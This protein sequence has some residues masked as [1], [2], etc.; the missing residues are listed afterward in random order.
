MSTKSF[1]SSSVLYTT[2]AIASLGSPVLAQNI[3]PSAETN[4]LV[5]QNN[6]LYTITGGVV[7]P[8][9]F[10]GFHKFDIFNLDSG[11]IANFLTQ[12][13]LRNLFIG[14]NGGDPSI[15]NGL[16]ELTGSNANFIFANPAGIVFGQGASFNL[17]ADLTV[18]TANRIGFGEDNW[19]DVLG[20][21]DYSALLGDPT[22][23]AFDALEP[24][25]ILNEGDI[26]LEN[27]NLSFY[28]GG[29]AHTGSIKAGKVTI[30]SVDGQTTARFLP[31]GSLI[32]IEV[33]ITPE[34]PAALSTSNLPELEQNKSTNQAA[35]PQINSGD[36]DF[37]TIIS[38]DLDT[39]SSTEIGGDIKVLGK[40]VLLSE[41]AS[42]DASG[43]LGGGDINIGGS[44][45]GKGN[46]ENSQFTLVEKNVAINADAL[47]SGDGGDIIIWAD[48]K[49]DF[50]GT[51]SS[52]GGEVSGD[53]GFA[54]ISGKNSLVYRGDVDLSANN[55]EFGTLLFDPVNITIENGSGTNTDSTFFEENLEALDGN[56]DVVLTATNNI[57]LQDL[58]DNVLD[59]ATGSGTITITADADEDGTGSFIFESSVLFENGLLDDEFQDKI[60]APERNVIINAADTNIGQID[61]SGQ[62]FAGDVSITTSGDLTLSRNIAAF[63]ETDESNMNRQAGGTVTLI[64][65]GDIEFTGCGTSSNAEGAT[66]GVCI[67]T[68]GGDINL[69]SGRDISVTKGFLNAGIRQ[70]GIAPGNISVIATRNIVLSDVTSGIEY[71]D[72]FVGTQSTENAGNILIR[73]VEG[74]VSLDA[75]SDTNST[76][77]IFVSS[78]N[79]SGGQITVEAAEGISI[80]AH[81]RTEAGQNNGISGGSVMLTTTNGNLSI[82]NIS[83]IGFNAGNITLDAGGNIS[84]GTLAAEPTEGNAGQISVDAGGTLTISTDA[85]D[86]TGLT[87]PPFSGAVAAFSANTPG[88]IS[89]TSGGDMTIE[90]PFYCLRVDSEVEA[91]GTLGDIEIGSIVLDSG[92]TIDLINTYSGEI[93]DNTEELVLFVDASNERGNGGTI[94]ITSRGNIKAG[95]MSVSGSGAG[96]SAGNISLTSE[97]GFVDLRETVTLDNG[98]IR[99]SVVAGRVLGDQT[100]SVNGGTFNVTA[101]DKIFTSNLRFWSSGNGGNIILTS[102][103]GG[104]VDIT[105]GNLELFTAG[106][107]D[108]GTALIST[109]GAI[110]LGAI[111]ATSVSGNGGNLTFNSNDVNFLGNVRTAGVLQIE[112]EGDTVLSSDS[113]VEFEL[114]TLRLSSNSGNARLD[115]NLV[116]NN[117]NVDISAE[118]D[119]DLAGNIT[120]NGGNINLQSNN[121]N[122]TT[123]NL[124]AS[125]AGGVGGDVSLNALG[126]PETVIETG[127]IN[128]SGDTGGNIEIF[129]VERISAGQII[130]RGIIG[131]GGNVTIDPNSV[132]IVFIDAQG[133]GIGS[134]GTVDITVTGLFQATGAFVD[135]TGLLSSI[136]TFGG[137]GSGPITIRHDGGDLFIPFI[138]GDPSINGTLGALNSGDFTIDTFRVF[139]GSFFLGN[140]SIITSDRFPDALD[141]AI[142]DTLPK[143][144]EE[145]EAKDKGFFIDEFFTRQFES[146]F[147]G[148]PLAD[149]I[150]I[151]SI[152][153]IQDTLGYIESTTGVKPILVYGLFQPRSVTRSCVDSQEINLENE[154]NFV[155]SD[156]NLYGQL[157]ND[158]GESCFVNPRKFP[159]KD[160]DILTLVTVTDNKEI[161]F[162]IVPNATR[163]SVWEE[164]KKFRRSVTQDPLDRFDRNKFQEYSS[165]FYKWL[166]DSLPLE[167]IEKASDDE[168]LRNLTF[169]LDDVLR[170]IPLAALGSTKNCNLDNPNS[171]E[172]PFEYI[173]NDY[174]VGLMPS[175]SLTE[176]DYQPLVD[177][178]MRLAGASQFKDEKNL[179]FVT[180]DIKEIANIWSEVSEDTQLDFRGLQEHNFN[181]ENV[182]KRQLDNPY[183]IVHLATHGK[184]DSKDNTYILFKQMVDNPDDFRNLEEIPDDYLRLL[185]DT[186][187]EWEVRDMGWGNVNL[188]V[189]SACETAIDFSQENGNLVANRETE[190]G[191]AGFA[192]R[193]ET[194]SVLGSLWKIED[195]TTGAVMARFYSEFIEAKAAEETIIKAEALRRAQLSMLNKKVYMEQGHI[196]WEK[197]GQNTTLL[198]HPSDDNADIDTLN[199]TVYDLTDPHYWSPYTMVGSPW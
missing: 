91:L 30:Q 196:I 44:Y 107:N 77:Q 191:F 186:N 174:S 2:V 105:E 63:A 109:D 23:F 159:P 139:P 172:C 37:N 65:A 24:S 48:N 163:R 112:S 111:D 87:N 31:E 33:D 66:T 1:I 114:D 117:G 10:N 75:N 99:K 3:I 148:D 4:T 39:S 68:F 145:V 124:D 27:G 171:I 128:T 67:E 16:I 143:I 106:N 98:E 104:T 181:I 62:D 183:G 92:G 18:T 86:F 21:N 182:R 15:I 187:T 133:G 162:S 26:N 149:D 13:D 134:G 95:S 84:T 132:D 197:D 8:D 100:V 89:L 142:D 5:N 178:N 90:C 116:V 45:Q 131:D 119:I 74:S 52:R 193:A 72:N 156:D 157:A 49:T 192:H 57:T 96:S 188:L 70:P 7:T 169:I 155:P 38:G 194:N 176:T 12:Q 126:N 122:I 118:L 123:Q 14:V 115:S 64:S 138:V 82:Q 60:R 136:S 88:N 173:I 40:A 180:R 179:E 121:G 93:S 127:N 164:A 160:E 198:S 102:T 6:N 97:G 32:G 41:N 110:N 69:T 61:T 177:F 129:A 42:I 59:F 137:A 184:F 130:S 25:A 79:G 153:E 165:Q 43:E 168:Q 55:G 19:F 47:T 147:T 20:A 56:M 36:V 140:I 78:E 175:M 54:E 152:N 22:G 199:S 28:G 154:K 11:E 146:Y 167:E 35:L 101:F 46:L 135:D 29:V 144:Q 80:D 190:L 141:N 85:L 94:D 103:H 108:A 166:I 120:T 58:T 151:K 50:L 76:G 53:G 83:S 81:I 125:N 73:S 195:R 34:D 185:D 113:N 189:L 17:P 170:S 71:E 158:Q 51:L 9:N 150:R 161:S